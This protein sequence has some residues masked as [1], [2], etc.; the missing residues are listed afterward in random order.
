MSMKLTESLTL[1]QQQAL[2]DEIVIS[3]VKRG[4]ILDDTHISR[5]AMVHHLVTCLADGSPRKKI[6]MFKGGIIHANGRC[7]FITLAEDHPE[8]PN[9]E[10]KTSPPVTPMDEGKSVLSWFETLN[11]IYVMA[12][13]GQPI[14]DLRVPMKRGAPIDD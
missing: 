11:T 9:H 2:L 4:I 13:G 1:D 3:A 8:T 10:V 7:A 5:P 14:S 12:P 6:I